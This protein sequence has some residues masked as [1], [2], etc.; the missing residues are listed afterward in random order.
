[1]ARTALAPCTCSS[2]EFGSFDPD[3]E[4]DD[5]FTTGCRQST[6]RKFA[7]GHDA[8]LV[9]FLVRAEMAGLEI[10]RTEG[11]VRRTFLGAVHAAQAVSDKLAV[12]AQQQLEA[13]HRRAIKKASAASKKA[14][15]ADTAPAPVAPTSRLTIIKVGRWVYTAKI[16]LATGEATYCDKQ[17][18]ARKV[19][20]GKYTEQA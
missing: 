12:K 18:T 7:M 16:D 20:Q 13:A 5:T 8:K 19:A 15:K 1:M 10:A 6:H 4:Q 14:S 11:G 17:G 2:F 9:G 3:A